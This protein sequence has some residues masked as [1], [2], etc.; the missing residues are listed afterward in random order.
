MSSELDFFG[1][2][3]HQDKSYEIDLVLRDSK[4]NPTGKRKSFKTDDPLSLWQF[5]MRNQGRPKKR[6]KA[7]DSKGK[8]GNKGKSGFQAKG[9]GIVIPAAKEADRIMA[10]MYTDTD[11]QKGK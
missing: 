3:E 1:N 6:K 9:K 10:N 11:D 8:K 5:Y 7:H 4:G 2:T